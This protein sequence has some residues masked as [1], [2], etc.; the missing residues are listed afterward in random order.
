MNLRFPKP[1]K[2]V[3]QKL[4]DF[5]RGQPCTLQMPWCNHNPETTVLCHI[6]MFGISGMATKPPDFLAFHGCSECHRRE[7]EAGYDDILRALML[8]QI[9]VY[10][11]FG[12]LTP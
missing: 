3:N 7:K 4:R 9:R 10:E 5:A 11:R 8:T 1:A 6:R 12:T 2:H